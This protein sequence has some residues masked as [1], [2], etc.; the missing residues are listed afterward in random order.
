MVLAVVLIVLHI[1][2]GLGGLV[3]AREAPGPRRACLLR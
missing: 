2:L 1:L 3:F